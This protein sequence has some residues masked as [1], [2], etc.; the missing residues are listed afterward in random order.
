MMIPNYLFVFVLYKYSSDFDDDN[1][2]DS[3]SIQ[4]DNNKK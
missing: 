2:D 4:N 3:R 1:N